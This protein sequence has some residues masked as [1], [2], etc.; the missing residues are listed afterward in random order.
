[1]PPDTQSPCQPVPGYPS[2]LKPI[3]LP[4]IPQAPILSSIYLSCYPQFP[5]THTQLPPSSPSVPSMPTTE[6]MYILCFSK[7][8]RKDFNTATIRKRRILD[9]IDRISLIM[10]CIQVMKYHLIIQDVQWYLRCTIVCLG[11]ELGK[12]K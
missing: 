7:W 3:P 9:K 12:S 5:T 1:M 6:D 4:P 2:P 8:R 10:H 11:C